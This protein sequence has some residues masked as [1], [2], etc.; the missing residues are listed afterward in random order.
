MKKFNE[1][2][3]HTAH[4]CS[5]R[6]VLPLRAHSV[7]YVLYIRNESTKIIIVIITYYRCCFTACFKKMAAENM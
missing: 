5:L 6:E 7:Q 1:A 4:S 2:I 3:G